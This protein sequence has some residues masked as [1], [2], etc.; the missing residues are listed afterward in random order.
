MGLEE[1]GSTLNLT[2]DEVYELVLG[3]MLAGIYLPAEHGV[4]AGWYID[5]DALEEYQHKLEC[6]R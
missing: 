4:V 3:G 6:G 1:A 5:R 2:L